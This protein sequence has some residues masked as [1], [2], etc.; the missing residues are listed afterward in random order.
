MTYS[1]FDEEKYTLEQL[2]GILSHHPLLEVESKMVVPK[3][4]QF[5]WFAEGTQ[6]RLGQVVAMDPSVPKPLVVRYYSPAV[7]AE[8]I[9]KARFKA[10]T[11]EEDGEPKS[12]RL[13]MFQVRL[14]FD[15]LSPNGMLKPADQRQLRRCL[16]S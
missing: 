6:P 4:G 8:D 3:V 14:C 10:Q 16:E 5:V 12:T 11:E 13:T 2:A 9:T 7:G 1:D 15:N